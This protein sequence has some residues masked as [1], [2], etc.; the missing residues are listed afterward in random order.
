MNGWWTRTFRTGKRHSLAICMYHAVIRTRIEVDDWCFLDIDAFRRQLCFLKENFN[1][2]SLTEAIRFMRDGRTLG[3]A[4]VITFDDGFQNVYSLAFP[5]LRELGLPATVFLTT[6]FIGTADTPWACRLHLGLTETTQTSL[7]WDDCNFDLSGAMA[8]ARASA[9]IQ[10]RLKRLPQPELLEEVHR[11]LMTLVIDPHSP[12]PVD[13]PFRML[14]PGAIA[15]MSYSGLV[16]FGAHTATHAI[17]SALPLESRCNE[18]RASLN[19]VKALTGKP[20]TLF[21]YPNGGKQDYDAQTLSILQQCGVKAAVTSIPGSVGSG[22]SLLELRRYPIGPGLSMQQFEAMVKGLNDPIF[23]S[24]V[25]LISTTR[26]ALKAIRI[27]FYTRR[28]GAGRKN[29]ITGRD[30]CNQTGS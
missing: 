25:D 23:P 1:V 20:C 17:L 21:A 6:G 29:G 8:K 26:T 30:S 22:S 15:E 13:S 10:S 18:I 19:A 16:E 27:R 24:L 11:I 9:D 3:T 14:D 2:I 28:K 4:A 7:A 5:I 12:I